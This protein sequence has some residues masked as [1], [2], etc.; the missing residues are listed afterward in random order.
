M[1]KSYQ[2][3]LF[4]LFSITLG[5]QM[6]AQSITSG[7]VYRILNP[8]YSVAI[9]EDFMSHNLLCSKEGDSTRYDQMW[10]FTQSGTAYTIQNVYTG[11][12]IQ[13]QSSLYTA[14]NTSTTAST[15]VVVENSALAGYF[16]IKGT[17]NS[18]TCMHCNSSYTVVPWY[19]TTS[20]LSASEWLFKEVTVTPEQI[21]AA[22]EDYKEKQNL[23]DNIGTYNSLITNF[24]TDASCSQLQSSYAAMSDADLTE[25]MKALPQVII[26]VALKIKNNTWGHREQEFRIHSY[27]AYSNADSWAGILH[28]NPYSPI[29]NPTGIVTNYGDIL[30]V[31]VG[32]DTPADAT[33]SIMGCTGTN[34]SG[35]STT[36][37]KGLNI[38]PCTQ[39]D[40][41]MYINYTANTTGTKVIADFPTIPIHIESGSVYGYFDKSRHTDADWVDISQNLC[42]RTIIDVKGDRVL[43]HFHRSYVI[44]ACPS[45]IRDAIGWWDKL[46]DWEHHLMGIDNICPSKFNNLMLCISGSGSYM[47]A[48]SYHTY[49]QYETLASILPWSQVYNSSGG[50]WGPAHEIGHM[51]QGAIN[52]IA[53]TEVSNNLF[54][55]MAV[56]NIGKYTTRGQSVNY[57]A[58][59]F[60]NNTPFVKRGDVF[61]MTRMYYQLFLYFH[62]AQRDTLFYPKL[63]EALRN[64]PLVHNSSAS[65]VQDQLKFAEKCCEVSQTD[66]S[67]FF[68]AW[69]FFVPMDNL[70]AGD[71]SMYYV[72]LTQSQIDASKAKM[73]KY[74]K[75]AGNIMF[76]EDRAAKSKRT[77]GVEGYRMDFE[78]GV[79]VG[80]M[81]DFGQWAEY[82]SD[83]A[84]AKGYSYTQAGTTLTIKG[85]TGAVGFKVHDSDGNL[86]SFSNTR[87]LI[88]PQSALSKQ[89]TVLAAQANGEDVEITSS[90]NGTEEEQ[91]AALTAAIAAVSPYLAVSDATGKK[92]GY[93][94]DWALASLK[95]VYDSAV[96]AKTN[97]DQTVRTYGQ[98][99][100]LINSEIQN[101]LTLT[102]IK[103]PIK[104]KNYYSL[105]NASYKSYSL[106]LSG[107]SLACNTNTTVKTV[108]PRK[109]WEFIPTGKTNEYYIRN[110]GGNYITSIDKSVTGKAASAEVSAAMPFMV[111]DNGDGTFYLQGNS[112]SYKCL[113]CDAGKNLV[114]WDSGNTASHWY[115]SV[116]ENN[117]LTYELAALDSLIN[118]SG[119]IL[120]EVTDTTAI[121]QGNITLY[122]NVVAKTPTFAA[123]INN[124]YTT[125]LAGMAAYGKLND[126][127]TVL[128]NLETAIAAVQGQYN[129]VPSLPQA[130]S[131]S[132]VTWYYMK[133]IDKSLYCGID[134]AS[135]RYLNYVTLT[136][137]AR[138][139]RYYWWCFIP[140]GNKNEFYLYNCRTGADVYYISNGSL[141]SDKEKIGTAFTLA[142]DSTKFAFTIKGGDYLWY[143]STYAKVGKVGGYWLFE[144]ILTEPNNC[145]TGVNEIESEEGQ[146]IYYDLFGRRVENP[147]KGLYICNGKK[148][149]IK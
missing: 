82:M 130:S 110:K 62:A 27:G 78:S 77:D 75:K 11:R 112:E 105:V 60:R 22:R 18:G 71:Y 3:L 116:T 41:M 96:I 65:G 80:T 91:L 117:S 88:L 137:P 136:D 56:F 30:Y 4:T 139:N 8:N 104:E 23:T 86:I 126:Y 14:F 7:N 13:N 51:N 138:D 123:D 81:G 140:T 149:Y 125:R 141:K 79:A 49:Y 1:R 64:D 46:L 5:L 61:S 108:D 44:S 147:V 26:N 90:S 74:A 58:N 144:K 47:Y 72:T 115:L 69:G 37:K 42:K 102:N 52:M 106:C 39:D 24:F 145:L 54:S 83:T 133:N 76:I 118:L 40:A 131:E 35:T 67:E 33:L 121:T 92:A 124:L 28:T 111:I 85:G 84:V 122:S 148:V 127:S 119:T 135:S 57:C 34:F 68:E 25:A 2:Y 17:A 16:N 143:A 103:V 113:H 101:L 98:W 38:I 109:K 32:A 100:D 93:Y 94:Y 6:Q 89:L 9:S 114:G 73:H 15:M 20:T 36:L 99:S 142:L 48:T 128:N 95:A 120:N 107:T 134:T 43:Y 50:C 21:A 66:L 19:P 59:E 87:T 45:T 29:N 53:C 63:F 146:K 70:Y 129:V 10:I 132:E 55:N 31:F 12:Y 97:A